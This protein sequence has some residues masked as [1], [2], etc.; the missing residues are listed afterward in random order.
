MQRARRE[1]S[2]TEPVATGCHAPASDPRYADLRDKLRESVDQ[3]VELSRAAL[4]RL[5][6]RI[7]GDLVRSAAVP[8]TEARP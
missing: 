8:G 6:P 1:A 2:G 3:A 5:V 4:L 7:L